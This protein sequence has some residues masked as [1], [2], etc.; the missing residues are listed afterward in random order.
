LVSELEP[1]FCARMPSGSLSE[2]M[3]FERLENSVPR[4]EI[5]VSWLSSDVSW[6]FQGVSTF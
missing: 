6:V 1:S 4:L 2:L 3:S 5:T